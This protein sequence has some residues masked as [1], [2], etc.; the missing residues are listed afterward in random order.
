MYSCV[1][2]I[3]LL[4]TIVT[5]CECR[6]QNSDVATSRVNTVTIISN[7]SQEHF[8]SVTNKIAFWNP[9]LWISLMRFQWSHGS[10]SFFFFFFQKLLNLKM[11]LSLHFFFLF[12]LFYFISDHFIPSSL[13][14]IVSQ[15]VFS[16]SISYQKVGES[17]FGKIITI[18]LDF[19]SNFSSV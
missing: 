5:I 12:L 9:R 14:H 7:L 19:T 13:K 17:M 6:W 11:L 15:I 1:G 3:L 10:F 8:V 2:D 4:V 18:K 16:C